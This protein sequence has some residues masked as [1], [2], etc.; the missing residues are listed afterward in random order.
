M[1]DIELMYQLDYI[2][3]TSPEVTTARHANEDPAI[4]GMYADEAKALCEYVG[5]DSLSRGMKINIMLQEILRII[6]RKRPRVDSYKAL[7]K[8]LLE[9]FDLELIIT[10]NKTKH[11]KE[12]L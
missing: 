2:V 8:Y 3:I 11:E 9:E 4:S 12:N 5:I 7:V 10:S 6:P 1:M